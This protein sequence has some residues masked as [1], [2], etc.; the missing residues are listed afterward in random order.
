MIQIRRTTQYMKRRRRRFG[1]VW[2]TECA[3]CLTRIRVRKVIKNAPSEHFLNIITPCACI[4][5]RNVL[6]FTAAG[7]AS[8]PLDK[9][10]KE[11][12]AGKGASAMRRA[13]E[14]TAKTAR[15][16]A[17]KSAGTRRTKKEDMKYS[18]AVFD[19]D[20]TILDTLDDLTNTLNL[21]LEEAGLPLRTKD[22]VRS[23]VGNGVGKLIERA[24]PEDTPETERE[25][26]FEVFARNYKLHC[27]DL[28]RPYDGVPEL[29]AE[30]RARG[31][32]T[33]VVSN[34]VDFAVQQLAEDYFPG[35][36]DIAVG[37]R[38]G[39]KRKPA[40]DSVL[41]VMDALGV[42]REET[43]YIGDSDVDAET[44]KNAEVDF[45]GVEWGFR[46]REVLLEHG[47]KV[48][49]KRTDELLRLILGE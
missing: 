35:L 28:T 14:E 18:L 3:A 48:T 30:L 11:C 8:L 36:F 20:G 38:E 49:V 29:I 21:S 45:I 9:K 46:P 7:N 2:H 12:A 15:R 16:G 24:L 27:A 43:V 26:F 34:K 39:V 37:E 6:S 31:V 10:I 47:A 13:R 25:K 5:A 19:M 23:F 4:A 22:E 17:A 41:A 42:R 40:P 44:A 1:A 32:K 33:A